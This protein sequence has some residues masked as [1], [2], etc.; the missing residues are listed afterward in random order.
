MDSSLNVKDP[1]AL[2]GQL[3]LHDGAQCLPGQVHP[4]VRSGT[5]ENAESWPRDTPACLLRQCFQGPVSGK[6]IYAPWTAPK[7]A[8]P[9]FQHQSLPSRADFGVLLLPCKSPSGG[10]A[11]SR[12]HR[13]EGPPLA[14]LIASAGTCCLFELFLNF[15]PCASSGLS[16]TDRGSRDGVQG[17]ALFRQ[18]R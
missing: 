5:S 14:I 16:E 1:E 4:R 3:R 18:P 9:L 7:E 10:A 17:A 12:V 15:D 11:S 13:G 2:T 8:Q 6:Y